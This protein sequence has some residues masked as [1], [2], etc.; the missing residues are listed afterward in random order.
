VGHQPAAGCS[1]CSNPA[2]VGTLRNE[3]HHEDLSR[4]AALTVLTSLNGLARWAEPP[5]G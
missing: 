3:R 1:T 2:G 4:G 5:E